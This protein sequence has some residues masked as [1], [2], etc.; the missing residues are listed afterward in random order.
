M[1]NHPG[2][3]AGRGLPGK[4][5]KPAEVL[6]ARMA[7][8]LT[9]AEAAKLIY[10]SQRAWANYEGTEESYARPMRAAEYELFL[11]K[12][13]QLSLELLLSATKEEVERGR[14][15]ML[16]R[17]QQRAGAAREAKA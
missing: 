16:A 3:N 14:A 11:L 12:T 6:A 13:G 10:G 17:Q 8:G 7:A 1:G 5:P 2:R 15:E 4:Q 9:Q